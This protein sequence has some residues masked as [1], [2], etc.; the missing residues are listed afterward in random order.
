MDEKVRSYIG[1]ISDT[2]PHDVFSFSAEDKIPVGFP[3]M[4]GTNS[5][6]Q[7]MRF[8]GGV[9]TEI[10]GI[11]VRALGTTTGSYSETYKQPYYP[12]NSTVGVLNKGR[13]WTPIYGTYTITAGDTAYIDTLFD[14]ITN[15][16]IEFQTVP[17]GIFTTG[18]VT[19]NG[20]GLFELDLIP[21]L[22]YDEDNQIDDS[23][24][25]TDNLKNKKSKK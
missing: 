19:V 9:T 25:S 14:K 10:V 12:V 15:E 16:Y 20:F 2:S 22:A 18:G 8:N 24:S 11:A 1:Q 5:D 23:E 7:V 17:I 4:R 13:I 6:R 3:V 21:G